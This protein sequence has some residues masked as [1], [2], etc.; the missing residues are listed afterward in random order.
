[1]VL[2][3]GVAELVLDLPPVNQFSRTLLSDVRDALARLSVGTPAVV[4]SSDVEGIFAAGGD[5]ANLLDRGFD[6]QVDCVRLA[7]KRLPHFKAT[8]P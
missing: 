5:V 2:A 1:M 6:E 8:R 7:Q 4:V 3:D